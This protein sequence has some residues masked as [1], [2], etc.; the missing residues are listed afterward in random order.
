MFYHLLKYTL[1]TKD[2]SNS[3]KKYIILSMTTTQQ[4]AIILCR[5][6]ES[7]NIGSVCRAMKNMDIHQLRIVGNKSDYDEEKIAVLSVHAFNIWQNAQFY[8]DL[9]QAV[10][11]CVWVAGTTRRRGKMRKDWLLLPEE[12]AEKCRAFTD[13]TIA[14]VFGN[15]RTGLTDE[16]LAICNTGVTIPTSSK[17]GS[18]SLNLSHAVQVMAYALFRASK[19]FSPGYTPVDQTRIA[20]TVNILTDD[21]QKMGFFSL[22]GRPD[23]EQFWQNLLSRAA[24]SEGEAAYIEKIF[25]KAAGLFSK[26]QNNN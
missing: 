21:L 18:G 10:S 14:L 22:A 17:D 23:M 24:I 26:N 19:D 11:D 25:N 9:T 1:C 8:P 4:T 5:P 16:E 6:D 12:F 20:K 13:G 7:R 2:L 15:E 3:F